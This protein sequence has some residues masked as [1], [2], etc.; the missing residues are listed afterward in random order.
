GI[1]DWSVTGV[2]TCAL[3]IFQGNDKQ[4]LTLDHVEDVG[5]V[6]YLG[7]GFAQRRGEPAQDGRPGEKLPDLARLAADDFLEQ[8]VG[9][10]GVV[11]SEE[12]R[13]GKERGDGEAME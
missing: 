9:D 6:C 10:I 5:R 3:P 8:V 11:R 2:Q 1:R 4:V 13:V 7:D 12:R